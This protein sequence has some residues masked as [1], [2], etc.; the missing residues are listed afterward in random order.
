MAAP[1][2]GSPFSLFSPFGGGGLTQNPISGTGPLD[3]G[4]DAVS[5]SFN[6]PVLG[7][8]KNVMII[9]GLA[10]VGLLIWTRRKR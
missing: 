3:G 7:S 8:S 5:V 10:L 2:G 6:P 4:D 9:G 1:A